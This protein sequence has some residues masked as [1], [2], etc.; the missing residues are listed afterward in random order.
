MKLLIIEDS[1]R[2]AERLK[3]KLEKQYIVDVAHT[4]EDGL[5]RALTVEYS[6]IILDLNLPDI[7]GATVCA[8][9]RAANLFTPVMILTANSDK[10]SLVKLLD[11]GADDY[12]TKPFSSDELV[13]RITALSR[14]RSH[15]YTRQTI[16]FRDIVID[17]EQRTVHR[18]GVPITLRRKEFDILEYLISNSGRVLTREMILNHA[19]DSSKSNWNNTVDVHI[20]HLR[21][22]ID[23]P[24]DSPI[25][26]TAYG[27]GYRVDAPE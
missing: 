15:Q 25:I 4:G 27:L 1:Q 10:E 9:L 8:R 6:V 23:R 16:A 13:A 22:K 17:T 5:Q 20:N 19:W 2:L 26:K 24:F 11:N 14:R 18:S 7:S 21:D 3:V 12:V